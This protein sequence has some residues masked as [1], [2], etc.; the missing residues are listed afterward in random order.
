MSK[1]TEIDKDELYRGFA[2]L[3][4]SDNFLRRYQRLLDPEAFAQPELR[5]LVDTL[6]DFY[7]T[8]DIA[9]DYAVLRALLARNKKL[10]PDEKEIFEEFI[11]RLEETRPRKKMEGY[12][13]LV[14]ESFFTRSYAK[15]KLRE[16]QERLSE[17]DIE[18]AEN[19][20]INIKF[21]KAAESD[22]LFMPV[23]IDKL[24][25][26]ESAREKR[27]IVKTG[28]PLLDKYLGGGAKPGNLLV[29]MAPVGYGKSMLLVHFGAEAWR[30]GR[31][32]FHYSFENSVRETMARYA[33][34]ITQTPWHAIDEAAKTYLEQMN[35]DVEGVDMD[36][37]KQHIPEIQEMFDTEEQVG[38]YIGITKRIGSITTAKDLESDIL[39]SAEEFDVKP[40]LIIVDYGDLMAPHRKGDN[41]FE[42]EGQVFAELRDLA[43]MFNVPVW[44][45]T[46]ANREGAKAKRVKGTHIQASFQKL[47]KA[48]VLI[49]FS[50]PAKEERED[51]EDFEDVDDDAILEIIKIRNENDKVRPVYVRTDFSR[52]ALKEI[53]H[54]SEEEADE[55]PSKRKKR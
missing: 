35:L 50:R 4:T 51:E 11:D 3:A 34:N 48:D 1:V 9:P 30:R 49:G 36:I 15:M 40:D 2:L 26:Q 44:T 39:A 23:D 21:P 24:F 13:G 25:L 7:G 18:G 29:V 45:A 14:L 10:K 42:N 46:Q 5:W 27:R 17:G 43:E 31:N 47:Q 22:M 41:Q 19:V 28:I 20:L 53:A 6:K 12:Y 32:V 54:M 16:T 55:Q 38:S 37:L 8:H 52:A 33:A